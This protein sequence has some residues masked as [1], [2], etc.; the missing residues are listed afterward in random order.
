MNIVLG[1]VIVLGGLA[2]IL[3]AFWL[4]DVFV[5]GR[6]KNIDPET[7][8]EERKEKKQRSLWRRDISNPFG[9]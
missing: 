1:F 2:I 6:I 5:E 7:Y 8:L 3:G 9:D 4:I